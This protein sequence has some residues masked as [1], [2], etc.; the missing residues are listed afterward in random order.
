MTVVPDRSAPTLM[1]AIEF[2][3]EPGTLLMTDCWKGYSVYQTGELEIELNWRKCFCSDI[4]QI[5]PFIYSFN[6]QVTNKVN[7][8]IMFYL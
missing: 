6:T 5:S 7:Y 8:I 4:I 2:Y 3:V 1:A